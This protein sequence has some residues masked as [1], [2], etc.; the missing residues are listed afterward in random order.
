MIQRQFFALKTLTVFF[1]LGCL[2]ADHQR[3]LSADSIQAMDAFATS[4]PMQ[5]T[6]GSQA[7]LKKIASLFNT[8]Q[9]A[10]LIKEKDSFQE[11]L[12]ADQF[13]VLNFYLGRSYLA[14]GQYEEAQ[15]AL[16]PLL[17]IHN[18]SIDKKPLLL[19][20][21]NSAYHLNELTQV[22]QWTELYQDQFPND[23]YV[24]KIF[25][26]KALTY[27]NCDRFVEASKML[28][29]II[30]QFPNH[31]Q[32]EMVYFE[33]GRLLFKQH[34]WQASRN[35]FISFVQRFP[36][37]ARVNQALQYIVR[38]SLMSVKEN[39]SPNHD[40]SL[41]EQLCAD[42]NLILYTPGAVEAS[43]KPIYQLKL[44]KASYELKHYQT[45]LPLIKNY[46][47]QYPHDSN[48]YQGHLIA[49]LCY[50][51]GF[52]NA[53]NFALHA[54]KALR[55]KPDFID[56]AKLH[57]NLFS[58]YVQLAKEFGEDMASSANSQNK[59]YLDKAAEHL[60]AAFDGAPDSIRQEHQL[61][62]ANF[63][64]NKARVGLNEYANEPIADK[65]QKKA[66]EQAV[67]LFQR[68][69]G[70]EALTLETFT[71]EQEFFKLSI[72]Y[73]WLEKTSE[74]IR[75]LEILARQHSEQPHL[76]WTLPS[77]TLFSLALAYEKEGNYTQALELYTLIDGSLKSSDPYVFNA[78]KLHLARLSFANL[79]DEKKNFEQPVIKAILKNLNDLQ[80]R[81]SLVFEPIHLEAALEYAHMRSALEP[82]SSQDK[83]L[84]SLLQRAKDN[85]ANKEDPFS[86]EYHESLP[87]HPDKDFLL[88][89]YLMLFNAH[90][91][92][93]EGNIADA[94][95]LFP[96]AEIKYEL[97]K[98]LYTNL[99]QKYAVT[100]YLKSQ[101]ESKLDSLNHKEESSLKHS[102]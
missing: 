58:T 85:F 46:L 35:A 3:Q 32:M 62:L 90:I 74:Q 21:I 51:E 20:L 30:D 41:K 84:L 55:L 44:A 7:A 78:T 102:S 69:L 52:N 82:I 79:T 34:Q 14:L 91:A 23:T 42:L 77:R 83:Y 47:R 54:E 95:G 28:E 13:P 61:W 33:K 53:N 1:S 92:Y 97:A 36:E 72:L 22:E 6:S 45:A 8:K 67:V 60:F 56:S 11:V 70:Q 31:P 76:P 10:H 19:A 64:Y 93:L 38:A 65:A 37:G 100:N 27:K 49:A 26:I 24:A 99:L 101:A 80:S 89:A 59:A 9:Y 73:A 12:Q 18:V 50:Q 4:R 96:E 86:K 88:Q 68:A 17:G 94:N 81:K 57:Y 5:D 39:R 63:F 40:L 43:Q 29:K 66:A 16:Q 15:A 48:R 2:Y 87:F 75:I 98:T 25:F 71:L